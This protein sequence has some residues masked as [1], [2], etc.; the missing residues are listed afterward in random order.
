[1]DQQ[2]RGEQEETMNSQAGPTKRCLTPSLSSDWRSRN[3]LATNLSFIYEHK[4]HQQKGL[5]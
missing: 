1:M 5:P 2:R 3:P 4:T